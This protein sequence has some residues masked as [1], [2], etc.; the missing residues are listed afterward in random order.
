M[1]LL[2]SAIA[3]TLGQGYGN[4][5]EYITPFLYVLVPNI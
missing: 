3:A 4:V 2:I 5:I 1:L